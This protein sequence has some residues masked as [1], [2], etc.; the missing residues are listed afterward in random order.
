MKISEEPVV[1]EQYFDRSVDDL[2]SALVEVD[3]MRLWYFDNIPAFRPEPGFKTEFM[4]RTEEREFLHKWHVT[5]VVPGRKI[6]YNWKFEGYEGE[7]DSIFE[8]SS[9]GQQSRLIV[10]MQVLA[11]YTDDIPEFTRESCLGGWEYFIGESLKDYLD[12]N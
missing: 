10:T 12:A 6:V 9:D 4:V 11:D 8:L 3:Q 2:W 5:E 1:V 7:A